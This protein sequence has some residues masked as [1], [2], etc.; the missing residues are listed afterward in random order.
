VDAITVRRWIAA[1]PGQVWRR[2][3]DLQRLVLHD[4]T[5]DLEDLFGEHG[6]GDVPAAGSTATITR[7]TGAHVERVTLHVE[8]R[9]APAHVTAT[10]HVAGER[11]LLTITI[12]A[13]P[14]DAGCGSDVR[15]H[16]ERDPA[17]VR[18]HGPRGL[19]PS[20]RQR[21]AQ[22]LASLL[23]GL[24]RQVGEL[25]RPVAVAP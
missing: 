2:V 21:A 15:F 3:L 7:R 9:L 4:R 19:V 1:P 5:L 18:S 17:A 13:M 8:E 22:S 23:E 6:D 24:A 14:G 12:E 16:A 25:D 10:V 11:W 20:R